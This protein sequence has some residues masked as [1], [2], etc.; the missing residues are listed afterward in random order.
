[1]EQHASTDVLSGE[2]HASHLYDTCVFEFQ[3]KQVRDV[4]NL[5]PPRESFGREPAQ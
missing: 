5:L 4:L 1:M 3:N 2:K